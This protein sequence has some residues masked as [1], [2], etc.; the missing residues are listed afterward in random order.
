MATS[1]LMVCRELNISHDEV[2]KIAG[3]FA[4]SPGDI[5]G[6]S[7]ETT[8]EAKQ[9]AEALKAS[10]RRA[11]EAFE[12]EKKARRLSTFVMLGSFAVGAAGL[13]LSWRVSMARISAAPVAATR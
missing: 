11:V 10:E 4:I 1:K 2:K 6:K 8:E 5:L 9:L 7:A 3:G 12:A 13:Y